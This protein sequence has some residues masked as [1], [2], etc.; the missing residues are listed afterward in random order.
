MS[1]ELSGMEMFRGNFVRGMSEEV[2]GMKS[3]VE[4][5]R[6]N[7]RAGKWRGELSGGIVGIGVHD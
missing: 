1:G 4:N 3:G 2:F 5:V 6:G 7:I